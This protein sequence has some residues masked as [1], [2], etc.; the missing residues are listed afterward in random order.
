MW[1]EIVTLRE[2]AFFPLARLLSG[3]PARERRAEGA[4]PKITPGQHN[5]LQCPMA[6]TFALPNHWPSRTLSLPPSLPSSLLRPVHGVFVTCRIVIA[7]GNQTGAKIMLHSLHPVMVQ[8]GTWRDH[9]HHHHRH[10]WTVRL[11][12]SSLSCTT[13]S[14]YF[15]FC[16]NPGCEL[17]VRWL[18]R[19]LREWRLGAFLVRGCWSTEMMWGDVMECMTSSRDSR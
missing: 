6:G 1:S 7:A 13:V 18:Q 11:N 5:Y 9:H 16:Q 12:S 14:G 3:L 10:H 8:F 17:K 15:L 4:V 19:F 2:E